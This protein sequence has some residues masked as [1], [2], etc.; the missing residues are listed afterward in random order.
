MLVNPDSGAADDH[1]GNNARTS[2]FD[3]HDHKLALHVVKNVI[4]RLPVRAREPRRK[5][6]FA[7][8]SRPPSADTSRYFKIGPPPFNRENSHDTLVLVGR[9]T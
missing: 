9:R 7:G 4:V 3:I 5:T 1:R 2:S 8:S 6:G